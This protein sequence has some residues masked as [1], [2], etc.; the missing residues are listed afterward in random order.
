MVSE[1][2]PFILMA[3]SMVSDMVAE[4]FTSGSE[5]RKKTDIGLPLYL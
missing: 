3:R 2:L 5:G 4:N 1:I